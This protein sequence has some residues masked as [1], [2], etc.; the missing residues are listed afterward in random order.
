M[1][2]L[3]PYHPII[4]AMLMIIVVYGICNFILTEVIQPD[5]NQAHIR[6]KIIES[7]TKDELQE[8]ME[9]VHANTTPRY[10]LLLTI[11]SILFILYVLFKYKTNKSEGV[12]LCALV[13]LGLSGK[14]IEKLGLA[15]CLTLPVIDPQA[16]PGNVLLFDMS[17]TNFFAYFIDFIY[18]FAFVQVGGTGIKSVLKNNKF[19]KLLTDNLS[20]Y[21][22]G[23]FKPMNI[24]RF[25]LYYVIIVIFWSW[26]S[27]IRPKIS[28]LVHRCVGIPVIPKEHL[29]HLQLK[30]DDYPLKEFTTDKLVFTYH[31]IGII[32]AGIVEGLL[33]TGL[34]F[35]MRKYFIYS[36]DNKSDFIK[37][38]WAIAAKF[39]SLTIMIPTLII[40]MVKYTLSSNTDEYKL[41]KFGSLILGQYIGIPVSIFMVQSLFKIP[42]M[43]T[44]SKYKY[45]TG[46]SYLLVPIIV[47]FITIYVFKYKG[48]TYIDPDVDSERILES[49]MSESSKASVCDESQDKYKYAVGIVTSVFCILCFG[50]LLHAGIF[51][52]LNGIL[53]LVILI[54]ILKA[55]YSIQGNTSAYNILNPMRENEKG[56]ID[57]DSTTSI[58]TVLGCISI[59]ISAL[60]IF[61]NIRK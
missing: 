60:L 17:Y 14:L 31:T 49:I 43:E 20:I 33:F 50:P 26:G 52:P 19:I 29:K 23:K 61:R 12:A 57:L 16:K 10:Y 55:V 56:E 48:S 1:S 7:K 44:L 53:L 21:S 13:V 4:R 30:D 9:I 39:I 54:I 47:A 32:A 18:A 6:D 27:I 11:C 58:S 22:N 25:V 15:N 42:L 3:D 45:I 41:P 5:Y 36:L 28:L 2:K 59:S 46:Y 38:K 24:L 35:P 37:D 34:L 51:Q 8:N 40:L